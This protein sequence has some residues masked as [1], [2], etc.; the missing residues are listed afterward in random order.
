MNRLTGRKTANLS[1]IA[2]LFQNPLQLL[3]VLPAIIIGLTVH[4]WAHAYSAFRLGDPTARN[5]GRMTLNPIAHIDPIGF[6]MLLVVGF[7]WAKPVPVNP[8][9]FKNYKRDDIVVSL[10]GIFS[11]LITAFLFSFVYVAGVLKWGL[12]TNTAFMSIFGSIITINL[13]LAIFNLIPIYPLDG[14]HVLEALLIRKIPRFFMFLRQY[15]Q[16]ILLGL[17]LTGVVS[18]VL[19]YLISGISSGFFTVAAWFINLF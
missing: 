2:Q 1:R 14:S 18:T 7:G 16:W 3:Y 17:L 9:N 15:G 19:G 8:R 11:N 13:A 6:I 12:G 4:E 5:L 10:A